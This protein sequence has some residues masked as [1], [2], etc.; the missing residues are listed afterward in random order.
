MDIELNYHSNAKTMIKSLLHP[1]ND[2]SVTVVYRRSRR[3]HVK[4]KVRGASKNKDLLTPYVWIRVQRIPKSENFKCGSWQIVQV[5]KRFKERLPYK[6]PIWEDD[7][8]DGKNS[9]INFTRINYDKPVL[10]SPLIFVSGLL[11]VRLGARP[12]PEDILTWSIN[13]DGKFFVTRPGYVLGLIEARTVMRKHNHRISD[14]I[15]YLPKH[16]KELGLSTEGIGSLKALKRYRVS[17]N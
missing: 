13:D 14:M 11:G 15:D 17:I 16:L 6:I 3:I 8:T 4:G 5:P 12:Y 10:Q 2:S 1:K 9:A 7:Y